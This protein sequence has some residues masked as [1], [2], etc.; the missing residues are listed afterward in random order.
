M[1]IETGD[2]AAMGWEQCTPEGSERAQLKVWMALPLR[3]KL[4]ALEEMCDRSRRMIASRRERGL[5]YFDPETGNL[6][7]GRER[8]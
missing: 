6:V 3:T 4:E 2:P 8:N 5:P 7:P 1:E